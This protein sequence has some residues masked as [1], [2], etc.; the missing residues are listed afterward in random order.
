MTSLRGGDLGRGGDLFRLNCS[1][2]HNFTARAARCH[3]ASPLPTWSRQRAADPRRD[4]H[5]AAEH[6]EVFRPSALIRREE[7]IIAYVKNVTRLIS[8]GGNGLG[9]FGPAP[10]G[11]VAWIIGMVAVI[12]AALWIGARS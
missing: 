2:C 8:P 4:A 1:S 7:D 12:G 11:M 6:A 5:R 10:E 3:R 9:G